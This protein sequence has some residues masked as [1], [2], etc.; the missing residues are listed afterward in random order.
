MPLEHQQGAAIH[1]TF[2]AGQRQACKSHLIVWYG[3]RSFVLILCTICAHNLMK[4]VLV[5]IMIRVL[6]LWSN[7]CNFLDK[8]KGQKFK[9][10]G[11]LCAENPKILL[12]PNTL[13]VVMN[14]QNLQTQLKIQCATTLMY[15]FLLL[16]F[17]CA[18]SF[19]SAATTR[20]NWSC[21]Y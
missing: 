7:F 6:M 15:H 17:L 4:L 1:Q 3:I 5:R 2:G 10:N 14:A 21:S 19:I 8:D 20:K 18:K 12:C 13:I 16:I 11:S 9:Q